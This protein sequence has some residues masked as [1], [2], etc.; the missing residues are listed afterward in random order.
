MAPNSRSVW[1]RITLSMLLKSC[2]TPRPGRGG[3]CPDDAEP[4]VAVGNQLGGG[5]EDDALLL[6]A[7]TQCILCD[8]LLADV[9][10][11]PQVPQ[12]LSRGG[13][14]G[15]AVRH[16]R[17][18]VAASRDHRVLEVHDPST[19]LDDFLEMSRH[20]VPLVAIHQV[21][22]PLAQELVR[23]EADDRARIGADVGVPSLGV[24]LP[25]PVHGRLDERA[26]L[27]LAL[28]APGDHASNFRRC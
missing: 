7:P 16:E 4:G 10:A 1:P 24:H 27:P 26:E 28:T 21:E 11:G 2:A 17:H 22:W 3:V 5:V 15:N 23:A 14:D 18:A 25:D 9:P 8:L 19:V 6:L 12:P 13:E 20:A